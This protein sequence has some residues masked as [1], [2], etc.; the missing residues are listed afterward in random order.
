MTD[1]FQFKQFFIA[2]DQCAMKVNTDGILLGS[3]ADVGSA[4]RIL[5]LGTGTGLVAIMLAQRSQADITGIEIEPNAYQ[6]AV[7]NCKKSP[8]SDR[9]QVL[10]GD[11]TQLIL[12]QKFDLIV[13]NPP[14]FENALAAPN[15]SRQLARTA[16]QSHLAWLAAAKKNLTENGKICFILPFENAQKLIEQSPIIGLHCIEQWYI[17]TQIGK[18]PKRMVITF[19]LQQKPCTLHFL[20]IYNEENRYSET[21]KQLTKDFYLNF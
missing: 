14:Y 6:Q 9:L 21:F 15:P 11:A 20:T 3:L 4:K 18:P 13:A 7:E 5:D 16:T 10:H 8:F 12:A 19:S 17:S 2:H 1:G